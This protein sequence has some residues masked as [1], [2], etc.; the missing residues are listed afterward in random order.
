MTETSWFQAS[1]GKQVF[2]YRWAPGDIAAIRGVIHIAHGMGEHAG[3]Y[4]WIAGKLVDAGYLVTADDH[5][6]HGKTAITL[7]DFGEDG[8]NR[9]LQDL[10]EIISDHRSSHPDVPI[11]LLGHSMGSM[12]AQH[13]I[14]RWSSSI[15]ALVL[16][17]SPGYYHPLQGFIVRLLVRFERWRLGPK[18]DSGLL[19]N[20]IF[21]SANNNFNDEVPEPSGFEWL[22]RDR[23]QVQAYVDDPLCGF[24]PCT[25]SLHEIFAGSREAQQKAATGKIRTALPVYLFAGTADPVNNDLKNIHR[26]LARYEQHGLDVT[27]RFYEEGR[28]EMFNEINRDEVAGDLLTWLGELP[29]ES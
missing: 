29:T 18:A 27:T 22:S 21:G 12:L 15:D 9:A 14:T 16:S 4:D 23:D 8:W 28:H 11:I 25:G 10:F 2:C 13:Y 17:G 7:G 19:Q 26:M 24:V 6:G 3:R 1:D 20:V 5:R